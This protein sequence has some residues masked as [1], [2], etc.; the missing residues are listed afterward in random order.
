M[1]DR[2]KRLH[3]LRPR[4]SE[5][6]GQ[7]VPNRSMNNTAHLSFV[8][9][10]S[11]DTTSGRVES[12]ACFQN[13]ESAVLVSTDV[14]ARGLDFPTVTHI[15]QYDPPGEIAEYVQRVGRTARMG[16]R[17]VAIL[18]LSPSEIEYAEE[19]K[20]A[21]AS[22]AQQRLFPSLAALPAPPVMSKRASSESD[23]SRRAFQ[24][25]MDAA[26]LCQVCSI[27]KVWLAAYGV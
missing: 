12:L 16:R 14:A 7:A 3:W 19:L 6:R 26:H 23:G 21:G 2:H 20:T 11:T 22:L 5:G 13:G 17:G 27:W 1:A 4:P 25:A 9:R 18:F 24:I 10:H 15:I 8:L